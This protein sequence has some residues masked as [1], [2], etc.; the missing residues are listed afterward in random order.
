[1]NSYEFNR[2]SLVATALKVD[3]TSQDHIRSFRHEYLGRLLY[4]P[5]AQAF[6]ASPANRVFARE[7]LLDA[8]VPLVGHKATFEAVEIGEGLLRVAVRV[9][10]PGTTLTGELHGYADPDQLRRLGYPAQD[11]TIE[12]FDF[13]PQS[14]LDHFIVLSRWTAERYVWPEPYAAQFILTGLPPHV[15]PI[16]AEVGTSGHAGYPRPVIALEIEPWSSAETVE[17]VY[18]V[19]QR[20]LLGRINQRIGE[21][22]LATWDATVPLARNGV[23]P[24]RRHHRPPCVA[25]RQHRHVRAGLP[26]D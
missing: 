15:P 4:R 17:E 18:R 21:K 26:P 25:L 19:L 2:T 6:V 10:P 11:A 13:W 23:E 3:A 24:L 9:D 8:G 20:R 1:M 16:R 22:N 5:E 14:V 12:V 7:D